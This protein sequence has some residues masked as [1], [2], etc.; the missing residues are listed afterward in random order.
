MCVSEERQGLLECFESRC[1]FAGAGDVLVLVARRAVPDMKVLELGRTDRQLA[2]VCELIIAELPNC[3]ARRD[4]R[5]FVEPLKTVNSRHD[6]IVISPDDADRVLANP[7]RNA[8]RVGVV[9]DQVAA[10]NDLIELAFGIGQ[11]SFQCRPVGVRIAENEKA[12][13]ITVSRGE[14]REFRYASPRLYEARVC[15]SG[16]NAERCR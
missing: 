5:D 8:C 15:S 9:A 13:E 4:L 1:C 7:I 3:P 12:H 14:T 10:A 16:Y 6:L 2:E 11:H